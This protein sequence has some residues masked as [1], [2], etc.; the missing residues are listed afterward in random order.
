M[1]TL[2]KVT[3]I[4]RT[5]SLSVAKASSAALAIQ[6]Q[7]LRDFA[8]VWKRSAVVGASATPQLGYT[9]IFVVDNVGGGLSGFHFTEDGLPYAVVQAGPLWSLAASHEILEMLIDPSA[10][11]FVAGRT[12]DDSAPCKYILE[13]CDPCQD[14]HYSY[15]MGGWVVSDFCF[16]WYFDTAP[17]PGKTYSFCGNIKSP[18]QVLPGGTLAWVTD[19]GRAIQAVYGKDG[20]KTMDRGPFVPGPM[21]ARLYIGQF[22]RSFADIPKLK[23]PLHDRRS[24]N[25]IRKECKEHSKMLTTKFDELLIPGH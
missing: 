23:A 20:L 5:S 13:V 15:Q 14:Y 11:E 10:N 17:S 24:L 3:I 6:E 12:P 25:K 22:E 4:P 7:I 18:R 8:P 1:G 2:A 21:P 16:P 19:Q 9:P